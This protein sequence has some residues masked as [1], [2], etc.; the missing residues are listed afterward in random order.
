MY[1]DSVCLAAFWCALVEPFNVSS[2]LICIR[3][4]STIRV[5]L[6]HSGYVLV[7][8]VARDTLVRIR[9]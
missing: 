8:T 3:V 9:L 5:E 4:S 6:E 7:D 2:V 1:Y